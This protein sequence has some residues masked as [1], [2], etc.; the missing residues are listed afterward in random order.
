MFHCEEYSQVQH[1]NSFTVKST[2]FNKDLHFG[3]VEYYLK[4]TRIHRITYYAGVDEFLVLNDAPLKQL[5]HIISIKKT[6]TLKLVLIEK[7]V[8]IMCVNPD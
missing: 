6:N 7:L 1:R 4:V 8:R 5:K 3:S 2:L